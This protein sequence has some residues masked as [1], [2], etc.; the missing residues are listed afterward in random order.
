MLI[1]CALALAAC[2]A[3][4]E[5]GE[6]ADRFLV[7]DD[8]GERLR[9]AYRDRG[10]GPPVLLIHGLGAHSYT[11]RHM[12]PELARNHRVLSLDLKGFGQSDKPFD[13]R[14]SVFDQAKLVAAFIDKLGLEKL[15]LIGHS[16]GGG[17]ALVLALDQ[18]QAGKP[19]IERMVLI[20][21]VA[22]PQKIP[23]FFKLLQTPVVAH[24]GTTVAPPELQAKAALMLAYHDDD[25]I[26][27][28]DVAAYAR[29]LYSAGSKHAMINSTRQIMPD[30]L[31]ELAK[32]YSSIEVP[33]L[34]LWCEFDKV[35]PLEIGWRLHADLPR[36]TF[37]MLRRCGHMP[38]EERPDETVQLVRNFLSQ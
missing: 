13:K 26:R 29:P 5:P 12:E 21:T 18:G 3:V 9:L 28:R 22:Y 8:Q 7:V 2:A 27:A 15:T 4:I 16:Y 1:C 24:L 19:R 34:I 20:D 37:R 30:N 36:S 17:I 32:R 33:T 38:Q 14:Y 10:Q 35:V 6:Q 25:K 11:W 31:P 23:I